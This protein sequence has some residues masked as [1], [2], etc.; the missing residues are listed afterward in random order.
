MIALLKFSRAIIHVN[1]EPQ[2]DVSDIS[3]TSIFRVDVVY[4]RVS[5][6]FI[7][8]YQVDAPSYWCIML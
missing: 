5:L 8:V 6:I 3:S 7:A 1:V 2:T 4:D